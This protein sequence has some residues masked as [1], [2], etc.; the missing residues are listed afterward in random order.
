MSNTCG[1]CHADVSMGVKCQCALA[2]YR[3][4]VIPMSQFTLQD[5]LGHSTLS[6][7]GP[8]GLQPVLQKDTALPG[9]LCVIQQHHE[10][11]NR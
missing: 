1:H 7:W 3:L 11:P 9:H 8:A 5:T 6:Q 2:I 10:K 4:R